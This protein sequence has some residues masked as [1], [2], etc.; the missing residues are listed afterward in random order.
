MRSRLAWRI[1]RV[2]AS[3]LGADLPPG[4]YRARAVQVS[5]TTQPGE[6]S[7][8]D[9]VALGLFDGEQTAAA[10]ARAEVGRLVET[11][12]AKSSFKALA[13]THAEGRRWLTV[14][15]GARKDFTPEHARVAAAVARERA[16]ELA[17]SRLCWLAPVEPEGD[18][19]EPQRS[20]RRSSRGRSSPTTASSSTSP[21]RR[22]EEQAPKHLEQLMIALA[23]EHP[24]SG[25]QA[26][27]AVARAAYR[28][29]GRQPGARSAEP[30]RQRPHPD[31]ARRLRAG[32]R[33]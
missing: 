7:D 20:S 19:S 18:S 17:G 24:L 16:R 13:L 9:T 30:A 12:E 31:G 10:S 27:A 6:R 22:S 8:A 33:R 21:S 26:E 32:A 28:R 4:G 15:L 29:R 14:G 23:G 25:E 2:G 11:G 1:C 3:R 5:A